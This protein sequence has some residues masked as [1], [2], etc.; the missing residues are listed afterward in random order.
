MEKEIL[1]LR[2]HHIR[3][4]KDYL[5]DKTYN[6]LAL[7]IPKDI[8]L[9][10][11]KDFFK[12]RK[13]VFKKISKGK[14]LVKISAEHDSLC[15]KCNFKVDGGCLIY[16]KFHKEEGTSNKDI[17]DIKYFGLKLNKIYTGK[18]LSALLA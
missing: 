9:E 10:Y 16:E 14:S 17:E 15:E 3:H 4:F 11:G 8:I 2:G 7:I 5:T 6:F 18:E 12:N 1:T 13:R